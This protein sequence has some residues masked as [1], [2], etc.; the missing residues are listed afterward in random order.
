MII[1]RHCGFVLLAAARAAGTLDPYRAMGMGPMTRTHV[2]TSIIIAIVMALGLA[3][4]APVA[5]APTGEVHE[6]RDVVYTTR[7]GTPLHFD[8]AVPATWSPDRPTIV[9]VHGGGWNS[10]T[11]TTYH[12]GMRQMARLGWVAVSVEYRLGEAGTFPGAALDVTDA[13]NY[14]TRNARAWGIDRDAIVLAG[15]SAGGNLA[16]LVGTWGTSAADRPVDVAGVVAWSGLTNLYGIRSSVLGTVHSWL[17]D[18]IV[19]FTGC[20][21]LGVIS[22][23]CHWSWSTASPVTHVDPSDPPMFVAHGLDEL[24][25]ISDTRAYVTR[26][27]NAGLRT[28]TA[29]E[30]GTAHGTALQQPTAVPMLRFIHEVVGRE[31][32][33]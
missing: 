5:A 11:R 15:D 10:G 1:A 30:E 13:V 26:R 29:Y 16:Q 6:I 20:G 19:G 8:A 9:Y 33:V 32:P 28:T 17:D 25:P 18:A 23:Q 14:L 2:R 12:Q 7:D 4:A 22:R 24:V 21:L 27:A 31:S 3:A